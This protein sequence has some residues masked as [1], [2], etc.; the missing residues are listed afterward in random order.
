MTFTLRTHLLAAS[1]AMVALTSLALS[2]ALAQG[3]AAV[4]QDQPIEQLVLTESQ[5]KALIT[6]QKS[7]DALGEPVEEER[8]DDG[9]AKLNAAV[10]KHG[11]TDF[12]EFSKVLDN[13]VL[14]LTGIDQQTKTYVGPDELIKRQ[15]AD[16]KADQSLSAEDRRDVL[17]ELEASLTQLPPAVQ[18]K[19]NIALV[20]RYYDQLSDSK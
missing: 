2:S 8:S 1:L 3:S 14:V 11:F 19:E 16:I 18:F 15:I 20:L 6:A 7:I 17:T 10:K 12:A 9:L 5:I 13:V 4:T